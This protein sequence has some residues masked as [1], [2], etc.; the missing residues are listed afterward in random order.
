MLCSNYTLENERLIGCGDS[1]LLQELHATEN[2]RVTV[3][4]LARALGNDAVVTASEFAAEAHLLARRLPDAFHE[5]T[6]RFELSGGG[7]LLIPG[8]DTGPHGDTPAD[9]TTTVT[10]KTLLARQAAVIA[11]GFGH[12]VGFRCESEGRLCQTIVPVRAHRNEQMSTGSVYLESHTEQC[13]NIATRPDFI[14]LAC[15]RGDPC[16]ATYALSARQVQN[17]L[18]AR[19]VR[20]LR[21]EAFYTRIDPSFVAGGL[22][23]RVRGPM[24]VLSGPEADPVIC[25]D[26]NL[27]TGTTPEHSAALDQLRMLWL[28]AREAIVLETGDLLVLDNSRVVHGRSAY[29]PRHDGT[30]RWLARLQVAKSLAVSRFA[31]RGISP[32]IEAIGC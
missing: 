27:M 18:P 14:F 25:Y 21:D 19:T 24:A 7:V 3:V 13:F 32:V 10:H 11:A 30:D 15:L 26:E 5:A 8:L 20:L 23:D 6:Y 4:E 1:P 2:D 17:A 28:D 12:L 29:Q 22:T 31:R 16:A 9:P